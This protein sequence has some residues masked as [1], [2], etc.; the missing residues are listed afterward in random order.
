MGGAGEKGHATTGYDEQV[1]V[2]MQMAKLEKLNPASQEFL[3][4]VEEIRQA[5]AHHMYEEEGD[6]YPELKKNAPTTD[7]AQ[8][9]KRYEEEFKRYVG[10]D[11]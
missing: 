10:A 2:K 8:L 3:D 6:W 11:A 5:V 4:K 9:T 1:E 7:Q